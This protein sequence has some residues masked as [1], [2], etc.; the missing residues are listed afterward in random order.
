MNGATESHG[1]QTLILGVLTLAALAVSSA[2]RPTTAPTA[3]GGIYPPDGKIDSVLKRRLPSVHLRQVSLEEAV[4]RLRSESGANLF[5][6][7]H[8]LKAANIDRS[9]KV[10]V[11]LHDVSLAQALDYTLRSTPP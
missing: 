11:D 9:S 4:E 10:D 2:T 1:N 6:D 8:A 5:V 3:P 7:W